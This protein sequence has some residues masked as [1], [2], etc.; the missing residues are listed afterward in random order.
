MNGAVLMV[1]LTAKQQI[2]LTD[3]HKTDCNADVGP[4]YLFYNRLHCEANFLL[5]RKLFHSFWPC[6]SG[7]NA[8][9]TGKACYLRS[10]LY[11][12]VKLFILRQKPQKILT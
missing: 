12:Y 7:Y 10:I 5:L 1:L 4:A 8:N 9:L 3:Q 11:G 2:V 6:F